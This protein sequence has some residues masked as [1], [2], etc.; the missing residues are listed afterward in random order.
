MGTVARILGALVFVLFVSV[1]ALRPL[2]AN[3]AI[4]GAVR[5]LDTAALLVV[6]PL[7]L[8]TVFVAALRVRSLLNDDPD[9]AE[10]ST[11]D[12][13]G[14]AWETRETE[15]TGDAASDGTGAD[16]TGPIPAER[17]AGAVDG[18]D[19]AD[20]EQQTEPPSLL[21]GQGGAREREFEIEE[22]PPD[23]TLD[24]HLDHLQQQLNG[25]E[26][27]R[28]DLET[29]AEVA[30]ELEGDRT[31]PARCPQPH[32]EAVWSG[33][34][35]LGVA[36]GRYEVLDDGERVQCLECEAIHRLA[37]GDDD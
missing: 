18:A 17:T 24:E 31:V 19:K 36:T 26:T 32:C 5:D 10:P 22:K 37:S 11:A 27:L 6:L 35:V 25:D 12:Q 20:G 4:A 33:R 21:S 8:V 9:R 1:I 28:E 2:V 23:A 14:S 3:P 16:G 13:Q 15:A 29:M 7:V 30:T 34:T